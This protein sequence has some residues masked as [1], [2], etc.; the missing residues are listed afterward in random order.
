VVRNGQSRLSRFHQKGLGA[1]PQREPAQ[2]Q[3]L[4][5]SIDQRQEMVARQLAELAG[6]THATIREQDFGLAEAA[7]IENE[8]AGRRVARGV[9][10]RKIQRLVAERDPAPFAAPADMDDLLAVGQQGLEIGAGLRRQVRLQAR[11]E[12]ERA[13]G[14]IQVGQ[15]IAPSM[16]F[17]RGGA[18][19]IRKRY[20]KLNGY[21]RF[22]QSFSNTN[23]A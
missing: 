3:Q 14:D 16:L 7:G 8:L 20:S 21:L 12:A 18:C 9:L 2:I 6:E 13:C 23:I 1:L 19:P 11:T 17:D 5:Q 22:G 4:V 15:L 10:N